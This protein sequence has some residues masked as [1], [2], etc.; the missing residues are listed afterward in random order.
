MS[1][2]LPAV[3]DSSIDL[4][5]PPIMEAS[6]IEILRQI[7]AVVIAMGMGGVA[8][9]LWARDFANTG[10]AVFLL[11]MVALLIAANG[12]SNAGQTRPLTILLVVASLLLG[13]ARV[14]WQP[15]Y[16]VCIACWVHVLA[17]A[18]LMHGVVVRP[19]LLFGMSILSLVDGLK[20]WVELPWCGVSTRVTGTKWPVLSL[21]VPLVVGILFLVPLIQSNP[22][23]ASHIFREIQSFANAF[24]E[25]LTHWNIWATAVVS[26]IVVLGLGMQ[27]PGRWIWKPSW[28]ADALNIQTVGLSSGYYTAARNTMLTVAIIF[29]WFLVQEVRSMFF[30]TFGE[31]FA[32]SAY[33]HQ[34]AAW[35]TLV[36]AMSTAT[37]SIIFQP[38][39]HQHSKLKTLQLLAGV[40][41]ICNLLLVLAA[42]HRL[43]IYIEYNGLTRL[44]IVGLVG[45]T[46]VFAGFVI[47]ILKIARQRSFAW[48]CRQQAWA[49]LVSVYLLSLLPMDVMAHRWNVEQANR[50]HLAPLVQLGVQEMSDEGWMCLLPLI[51]HEEPIVQEGVRALLA[52]RWVAMQSASK[53]AQ[54]P[55]PQKKWTQYC[56]S[57]QMLAAQL[58]QHREP[59]ERWMES[60]QIRRAAIQRFLSWSRR[61]Y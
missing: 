33:A 5:A 7:R 24:A 20:R 8:Y 22:G 31:G 54:P 23:L 51:D 35:L 40:W 29:V 14:V 21:G 43:A 6:R 27:L 19:I 4:G 53:Y 1:T 37:L 18:L 28:Y 48:V 11:L 46:C 47:V 61:W 59:L 32:F 25:W 52:R 13:C 12:R 55:L 39:T 17:V 38:A 49:V 9:W 36:L 44:R 10:Y 60:E 58:E 34:G 41:S 50:G 56:G 15:N 30:R 42:Y 45:V 2:E 3:S 57:S 16:F 26:L